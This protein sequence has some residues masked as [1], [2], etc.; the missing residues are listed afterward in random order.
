MRKNIQ[1]TNKRQTKQYS[2]RG[3]GGAVPQRSRRGH[4]R[5]AGMHARARVR[6]RSHTC[7]YTYDAML[8]YAT[9]RYDILC[10]AMPCYAI[11]YHAMI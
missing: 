5:Q 10:Y 11:P 7:N 8:R 3:A 4:G 6:A 1:T 2:G 9:L